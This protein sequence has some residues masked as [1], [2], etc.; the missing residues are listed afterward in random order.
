MV[1][2]VLVSLSAALIY[3]YSQT[4]LYRTSATFIVSPSASVGQFSEIMRSLDTLSGRQGIKATYVEIPKSARIRESVF[5]EMKLTREQRAHLTVQ[6]ELIPSTNIIKI[7]VESNDP[8][9]AKACAD[10]IGQK[11]KEYIK[12]LY[13][14]YD[15]YPLDTAYVPSSPFKPQKTQNLFLATLLGFGIG[16][17]G[18]LALPYARSSSQTLPASSIIDAETGAYTFR[19][20]VQR[21]EEE[22]SRARRNRNPLSLALMRVENLDMIW[23]KQAGYLK[24]EA[25]R[26]VHLFIKQYLRQEDII[27]RFQEETYVLL[28]PDMSGHETTSVME[29]LRTRIE[30]SCF[31]LAN[32]GL[33]LNLSVT[34]GIA[35][36]EEN[37]APDDLIAR[38]QKALQLAQSNGY[39]KVY[40][41]Q[42]EMVG[43]Q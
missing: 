26:Q 1:S 39:G 7:T 14:T 12:E 6:S 9:I 32:G 5:Q 42:Q 40:L 3:T 41:F 13:E 23:S 16:V 31:E 43:A 30:W 29:K 21:L 27:S 22:I 25:L 34:V 8:L 20:F 37:L 35:D 19:Y 18:A 15:L 38:A 24:T 36:W 10:L 4:P 17:G 11:T 28:F 2:A 33:K